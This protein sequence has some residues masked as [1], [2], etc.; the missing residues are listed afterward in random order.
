M[1]SPGYL[2]LAIEKVP[3]TEGM[4]FAD[5][6]KPP[7]PAYGTYSLSRVREAANSRME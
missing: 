6:C 7:E 4:H 2:G 5:G 3:A 1:G